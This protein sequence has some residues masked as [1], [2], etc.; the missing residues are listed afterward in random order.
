[1]IMLSPLAN[2]DLNYALKRHFNQF[3]KNFMHTAKH[4]KYKTSS[5]LPALLEYRLQKQHS[6]TNEISINLYYI[7]R[8]Y[9]Q[10]NLFNHT[11]CLFFTMFIVFGIHA[12]TESVR[13]CR[14]N[15]KLRSMIVPRYVKMLCDILLFM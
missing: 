15:S 8:F 13:N 11:N 14:L 3:L 7:Y 10:S 12:V 5:W 2:K 4:R 1:M 9:L 6:N